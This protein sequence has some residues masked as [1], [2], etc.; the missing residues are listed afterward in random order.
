MSDLDSIIQGALVLGFSEVHGAD[1]IIGYQCTREQLIALC[2][3]VAQEAIKQ[4]RE[5]NQGD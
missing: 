1:G 3:I 5:E 4:A 2:T